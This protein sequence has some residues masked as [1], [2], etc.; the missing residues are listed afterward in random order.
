MDATTTPAAFSAP[1]PTDDYRFDHPRISAIIHDMYIGR[2]EPGSGDALAPFDLKTTAGVR[3]E[4]AARPVR[5]RG[6]LRH[7]PGPRGAPRPEH[8]AAEDVRGESKACSRTILFRGQWA[9]ETRAIGEA[10]GAIV[11]GRTPAKPAVT[12][13]LPALAKAIG[14]SSFCLATNGV[15]RS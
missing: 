4:G 1:P 14:C 2:A 10:L 9:N 11:A 5:E 12:R 15:F 6:S 3:V 7:G 13:M 8:P